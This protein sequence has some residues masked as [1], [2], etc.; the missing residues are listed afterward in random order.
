MLKIV[1]LPS[2]SISSHNQGGEQRSLAVACTA[3]HAAKR[4]GEVSGAR[5]DQSE[6]VRWTGLVLL[7]N[8]IS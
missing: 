7:S 2:N 8:F 1:K 6:H 3:V 5:D 4:A